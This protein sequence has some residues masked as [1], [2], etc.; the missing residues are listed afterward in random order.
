MFL[1]AIA[2]F[3]PPPSQRDAVSIM[4]HKQHELA[5]KKPFPVTPG[6]ASLALAYTATGV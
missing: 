2:L 3:V 4:S 1:A 5:T 6:R